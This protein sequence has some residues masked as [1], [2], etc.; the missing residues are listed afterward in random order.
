[1]FDAG[2]RV[3]FHDTSRAPIPDRRGTR[4]DPLH[5]AR[6]LGV[7]DVTQEQI[8]MVIRAIRD[9]MIGGWPL[10]HWEWVFS[11]AWIGT[12]LESSRG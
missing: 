2:G 8:D 7:E 10:I 5:I 4:G 1:M 9:P 6:E 11:E 3:V 12:G